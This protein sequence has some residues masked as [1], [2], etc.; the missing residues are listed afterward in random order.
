MLRSRLFFLP[1]KNSPSDATTASHQLLTRASFFRPGQGSGLWETLPLGKRVLDKLQAIIVS[2]MNAIEGC[3]QV[4]MPSLM[5][6]ETWKKTKRWES[7]GEE[8]FRLKD[9]KSTEMLLAPTHEEA[10]T[11]MVAGMHGIVPRAALPLYL[12]QIGRKFRDELRPRAG[13]LRAREFIMKDLYTFDETESKAMETYHKICEA[14]EKIFKLRLGCNVLK[15][16]ADSGKMGG[17]YSHEFHFESPVGEDTVVKCDHGGGYCAN[18][19]VTSARA[20]DPCTNP[21]CACKGNGKLLEVKCIEVGHAFFLGTKYSAPLG[22]RF[23]PE[24]DNKPQP[25]QMG[26]Y[27]LGVTR[28]LAAI[29][30]TRHDTFGIRWPGSIAPF[31]VVVI[32]APG[33]S[34]SILSETFGALK[35]KYSMDVLLDDRGENVSIS[36][37]LIDAKI[38]GTPYVCI[39][40]KSND[41]ELIDRNTGETS[42]HKDL[43]DLMSNIIDDFY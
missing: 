20:G 18:V 5:T 7:I 26:S 41:F 17:S 11:D 22:A 43:V 29:V 42:F 15:A 12:Y 40:R 36:S 35:S 31:Q 28:I 19:E 6:S 32:A 24:A 25:L 2:E 34:S 8:M 37:K 16:Q 9:R 33:S 14:Y 39:V 13:L 4:E 23:V 3:Q 38:I 1:R 10:F 30:E 27:G 21:D